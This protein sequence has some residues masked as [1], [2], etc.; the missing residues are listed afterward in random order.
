MSTAAIFL[1]GSWQKIFVKRE[2]YEG[3]IQEHTSDLD[4]S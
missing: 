4:E 1:S 2:K 3:Q